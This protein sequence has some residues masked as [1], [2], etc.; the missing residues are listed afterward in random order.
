MQFFSEFHGPE[1]Q[2]ELLQEAE[3]LNLIK[4]ALAGQQRHPRLQAW[5]VKST[6]FLKSLKL[7]K[8]S[9]ATAINSH[10]DGANIEIGEA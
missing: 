10:S 1:R 5:L 4:E 3:N 6:S 2:K 7:F 9:S 8:S